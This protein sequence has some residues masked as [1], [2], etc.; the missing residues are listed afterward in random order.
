M[1]THT[2]ATLRIQAR[3]DRALLVHLSEL[4]PELLDRCEALEHAAWNADARADMF[5]DALRDALDRMPDAA[6][7]LTMDGRIVILERP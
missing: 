4:V 1:A 5:Q 7:G 3:L 2:R 6:P